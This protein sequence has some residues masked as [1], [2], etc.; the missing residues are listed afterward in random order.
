MKNTRARLKI[1]GIMTGT[2]CDGL[3]AACMEIHSDPKS[4]SDTWK[5]LWSSTVSY[6]EKLRERVL[7]MQLPGAKITTHDLLALH[8]DLGSWYGSSAASMIRKAEPSRRPDLIANHG[9]TVAHFPAPRKLGTTL[10]LGDPTRIAEQTGLTVVSNFREGDMAAGGEGAPLAPRFHIEIARMLAGSSKRGRDGI[11]IHNLGGISN[12]TYVG[13]SKTQPT[14]F[15]FDTGPANLWIDEAVARATRGKQT[16][17]RGG[18]IAATGTM[19]LT[20]VERVLKLPYFKKGIPKSTGRDD[21]PFELL[22]SRTRARGAD[23]VATA[24]AVTAASIAD[25]YKR[26]VIKK[27]RLSAIYFSGGGAR[28]EMLMDS[29]AVLLPGV[30]VQS[31]AEVGLDETLIECQAFAILAYR[32]L[33]G[34]PLGGAWTGV[35][36]WGPPAHIIPGENWERVREVLGQL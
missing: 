29:V 19:D 1:L 21:F 24:T 3:D 30:R 2:S 4:G 7:K 22:A 33:R 28:N 10:Q 25:A 6:P 36:G 20:A 35:R 17:D 9:Q 32:T 23:L 11:A 31:I 16:F 12:L 5:C 26:F 34:E 14:V 15:A 27:H 8:R 18:M 13:G